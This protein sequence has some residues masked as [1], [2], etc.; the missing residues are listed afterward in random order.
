MKIGS[1]QVLDRT[2]RKSG[3]YTVYK[4]IFVVPFLVLSTAILGSIIIVLSFLGA[5]DF[6]SRVFGTLWAKINTTVSLIGIR[7]S[8]K[9]HIKQGQS[10]VIV[11]NH[12]SML[13]IFLLYG[14]LGMDIKW[15]M[16]RELRA[17]P[18]LGLACEMMGHVI[19]DRSNTEA[20]LA[21]ME[22]ARERIK[23][24]MS[25]VFFAE[26]TRSRSGELKPFKKG[27]FRMAQEL[28]LPILP[29]TIHNTLE[30]L[31]SDTADLHPGVARMTIGAR[32]S[33]SVE[34]HTADHP[35]SSQ[36]R[37]K[38]LSTNAVE[39]DT[40]EQPQS[41]PVMKTLNDL[42]AEVRGAISATLHQ[43]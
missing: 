15:V 38:L 8:G 31:P 9:E 24:G 21:S 40:A 12:Q 25:V 41:A 32:I 30:I 35:S 3:L 22:R 23:N 27:A 33:V 1:E 43:P 28:N 37:P 4:W 7:A 36:D 13:D 17:V 6:A 42:T 16:K 29:I 26:G 10:Y 34:A 19:I 18:I 2:T 14:Y 20:A 39:R 11:A 5:P